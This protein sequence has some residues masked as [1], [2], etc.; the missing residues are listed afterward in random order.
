MAII[1][2]WIITLVVWIIGTLLK[3]CNDYLR[4]EAI[5]RH[6][7][8]IFHLYKEIKRLNNR[9][10]SYYHIKSTEVEEE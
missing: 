7:L 3:C 6:A 2:L 9:L 4:T 5:E 1:I 10:D 8:N